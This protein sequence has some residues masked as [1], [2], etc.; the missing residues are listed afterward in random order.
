MTSAL[1]RWKRVLAVVAHPDD[2]SF[3]LGGVIDALVRSGARVSVLCLTAGEASTLGAEEVDLT[4]VRAA[5]LDLA[6][7]LLGVDHVTL[8]H[9]P[10]GRLGERIPDL[11]DAVRDAATADRPD[12]LLVFGAGGGVTGHPDHEVATMAALTVARERALP[13][14]EWC[15]PSLVADTL[16]AELGAAFTGYAEADLP[17]TLAVDRDRQLQAIAAHASQAVPGSVLWRRIELLGD[18]EHLRL[19]LPRPS[20]P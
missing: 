14:L 3:G 11:V 19:T 9:H 2:E 15:L 5:E 18:R 12:A 7:G 20:A 1:P 10:D 8:L 4:A 13:V 17:V 6:A 16:N